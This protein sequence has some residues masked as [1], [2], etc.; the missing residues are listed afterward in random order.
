MSLSLRISKTESL[1]LRTPRRFNQLV[2]LGEVVLG[3]PQKN[4]AGSGICQLIAPVS[5]KNRHGDL[6][7]CRHAVALIRI[8]QS[9]RTDFL[10]RKQNLCPAI[11]KNHFSRKTFLVEAPFFH[12]QMYG[13]DRVVISI[14]P[15]NYPILES[16]TFFTV[17]FHSSNQ[18]EPRS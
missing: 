16:E 2:L 1:F 10:F 18:K 12:Q 14:A 3:S 4:C 17:I 8:E 13:K 9:G 5:R 6:T 7:R 15:G 11:R